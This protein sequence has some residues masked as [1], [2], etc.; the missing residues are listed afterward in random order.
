MIP[1]HLIFTTKFND[2]S[3]L[4]TIISCGYLRIDRNFVRFMKK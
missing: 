4:I 3:I 1:Y 2:S